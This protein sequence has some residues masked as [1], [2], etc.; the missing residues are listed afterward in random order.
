M[1]TF[2]ID[3]QN[4]GSIQNVGGDMVVHGGVHGSANVQ[5]IELRG[6]LAQ[7]SEELYRLPLPPES[8]A[9]V[10]DALVDAETEAAAPAPR[11]D[12]IG[13]S[14]ARVTQVLEDAGALASAGTG[15]VRALGRAVALVGMLAL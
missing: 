8:H 5:V 6:R 4:A 3:N 12:R 15:L 10:R 13:R 9:A 2:N 14:L 1:T 7:L 11:S